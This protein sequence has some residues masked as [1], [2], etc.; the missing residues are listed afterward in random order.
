MN[1]HNVIKT[2]LDQHYQGSR[3]K[4]NNFLSGAS[5]L[6]SMFTLPQESSTSESLSE[7]GVAAFYKNVD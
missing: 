7:N 3:L 2:Y 6:S 5:R 4:N 1:I